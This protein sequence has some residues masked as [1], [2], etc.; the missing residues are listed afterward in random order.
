MLRG[1]KNALGGLGA[2]LGD[3]ESPD[4][5]LGKNIIYSNTIVRQRRGLGLNKEE[6]SISFPKSSLPLSSGGAANKD[7]WR[8]RSAMTGFLDF[9]LYCACVRPH[10]STDAKILGLPIL[11]RKSGGSLYPRGPCCPL[12]PLD[13]AN[14]DSGNEIE[15]RLDWQR[16]DTKSY[17]TAVKRSSMR[18]GVNSGCLRANFPLK[19]LK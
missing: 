2:R 18:K 1:F 6:R 3:W 15:E 4:D 17:H 12:Q 14:E 8:K 9:R 13:K 5:N 7:L 10:V 19:I 16:K 11:L